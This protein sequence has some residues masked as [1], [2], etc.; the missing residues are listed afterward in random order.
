MDF[1]FDGYRTGG[2]VDDS[3]INLDGMSKEALALASVLPIIP[4]LMRLT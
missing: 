1:E 2:D 4:I 3:D